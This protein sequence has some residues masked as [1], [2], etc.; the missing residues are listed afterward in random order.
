MKLAKFNKS[1]NLKKFGR[2]SDEHSTRVVRFVIFG[3]QFSVRI[4]AIEKFEKAFERVKIQRTLSNQLR[5][6]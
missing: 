4:S 5:A 6:C 3:K 1:R 2:V